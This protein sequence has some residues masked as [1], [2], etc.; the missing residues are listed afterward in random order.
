MYGVQ[1][2]SKTDNI[3]TT[4]ILNG[5]RAHENTTSGDAPGGS[6]RF[7]C[8]RLLRH[9][10]NTSRHTQT[11]SHTLAYPPSPPQAINQAHT[12]YL[13]TA[14]VTLVW[15]TQAVHREWLH[16]PQDPFVGCG[17]ATRR[18]CWY[19]LPNLFEE[20]GGG[21]GWGWSDTVTRSWRE[22][23]HVHRRGAAT[24]PWQFHPL[25]MKNSL[26]AELSWQECSHLTR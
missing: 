16:I 4:C 11:H 9:T 8:T 2:E 14:R 24:A 5:A 22:N 18:R 20:R 23:I 6:H 15:R 17:C 1:W 7:V 12:A 10:S 13:I 19:H 21:G 26:D 3:P 25:H